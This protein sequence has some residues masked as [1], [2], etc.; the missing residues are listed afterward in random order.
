VSDYKGAGFNVAR[1]G[2]DETKNKRGTRID[3]VVI[4]C[5]LGHTE[6]YSVELD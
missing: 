3:R 6:E 5:G 2:V 4:E 1:V